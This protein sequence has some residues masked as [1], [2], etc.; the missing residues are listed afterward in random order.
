MIARM[1]VKL[2]R[3]LRT[4]LVVVLI[5]AALYAAFRYTLHRMVEARLDEIRQQGYPVTPEEL[6]RLYPDVPK[7]QNA[8]EVYWEA[9]SSYSESDQKAL[10]NLPYSG[11]RNLPHPTQ[12]V[13]VE[14]KTVI[15]QYLDKNS[16]SLELYH[17]GGLIEKCAYPCFHG[18]YIDL[19][20]TW[21]VPPGER[22]LRLEAVAQ[23]EATNGE[24]ATG[25]IQDSLRLANSLAHVP[26]SEIRWIAMVNLGFSVETLEYILSRTT[27]ADA[28]L[29]QLARTLHEA[30]DPKGLTF[31]LVGSQCLTVGWIADPEEKPRAPADYLVE[32]TGVREILFLCYVHKLKPFV[33]ASRPIAAKEVKKQPRL[34]PVSR[35]LLAY[36]RECV[37]E[38]LHAT[39][40]L[41]AALIAVAIERHHLIGGSLPDSL[42]A[43]VPKFLAAVPTDPF[44]G[45]PLR[46]KK[47]TKGYVVYSVGED[48][49]DDG[50]DEK[51]DITF[52]VER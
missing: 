23:A 45:Q 32:A 34:G 37:V 6:F 35:R 2:S 4:A 1:S 12:P 11:F 28:Q 48:G 8:W 19:A 47:L 36:T 49:K 20:P 26:C 16:K 18:G 33:E 31:A 5:L 14:T 38:D 3:R 13:P 52:T 30:D 46:Y 24:A 39:A 44:D 41:R 50:G 15:A 42:D 22:L 43:L 27:L 29:S 21:C 9:Y 51:K 10:T 7:D 25:T 40:Q 17:R